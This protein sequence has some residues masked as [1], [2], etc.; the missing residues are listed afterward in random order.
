MKK[1]WS[2]IQRGKIITKNPIF[3]NN[4][5]GYSFLIP[6]APRDPKGKVGKHIF[7]VL[8]RILHKIHVD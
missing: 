5:T 8:L 1:N 6:V 4:N 7:R 3:T 2:R